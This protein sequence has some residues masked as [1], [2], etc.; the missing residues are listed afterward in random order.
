MYEY[1]TVKEKIRGYSFILEFHARTHRCPPCSW[2]VQATVVAVLQAAGVGHA[3]GVVH[4][5][6]V[7]VVGYS[8]AAKLHQRK[9]MIQESLA[10]YCHH[11]EILMRDIK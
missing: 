8:T 5:K 9:T 2:V 6:P 1:K 3:G 4:F 10:F 7:R 11:T